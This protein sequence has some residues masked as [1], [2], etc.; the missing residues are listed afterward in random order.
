MGDPTGERAEGLQLPRPD[1]LALHLLLL[2]DVASDADEADQ[3]ALLIVVRCLQDAEDA[4]LPANRHRVLGGTRPAGGDD[5]P[6]DLHQPARSLRREERGV[7][8]PDDLLQRPVEHAREGR[9]AQDVAAL[10]VLQEDDVGRSL[11]DR[12]QPA[13]ALP[14]G[15]FRTPPLIHLLFQSSVGSNQLGSAL[16]HPLL[17]VGVGPA[18]LSLCSFAPRD[19]AGDGLNQPLP[20]I[21]E[22]A[23]DIDVN[24]GTVGPQHARLHPRGPLRQDRAERLADAGGIALGVQLEDRSRE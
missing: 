1:Q 11:D 20:A 16:L 23:A 7:V 24:N 3:L 18:E 5:P 9:V 17:Q 6:V 15:G 19:V 14:Q 4:V 2:C 12:A 22:P 8:L 21:Y 13:M 10:P